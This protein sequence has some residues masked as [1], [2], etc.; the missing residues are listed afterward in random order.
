V[1]VT[2]FV[3]CVLAPAVTDRIMS[4]SPSWEPFIDAVLVRINQR[5]R[6]Y[7]LLND[8]LDGH[9]LNIGQH[10]KDDLTASLN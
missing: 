6:S 4:I 1:P 3:P 7:E 10:V 9:L 5:T 8:W 2:I